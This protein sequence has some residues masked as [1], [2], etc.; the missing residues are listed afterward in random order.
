MSV[1][2][3]CDFCGKVTTHTDKQPVFRPFISGGMGGNHLD[4]QV[5]RAI[6]G[7]WNG[8]DIC[9]YCLGKALRLVGD[10]LLSEDVR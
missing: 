2:H 9:R 4:V 10:D 7:A 3:L 6:D 5:H 8:G 1:Q